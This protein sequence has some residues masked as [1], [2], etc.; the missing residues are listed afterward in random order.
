[1]PRGYGFVSNDIDALLR[2]CERFLAD[3]DLRRRSVGAGREHA[4]RRYGLKRFIDDWDG[5]LEEVTA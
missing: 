4:L 5:V 2:A 1:M 3:R